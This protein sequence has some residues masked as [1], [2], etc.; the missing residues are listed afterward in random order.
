M[1]AGHGRQRDEIDDVADYLEKYLFVGYKPALELDD[2]RRQEHFNHLPDDVVNK[3][4]AER[5]RKDVLAKDTEKRNEM[6][7]EV[8]RLQATRNSTVNRFLDDNGIEAIPHRQIDRGITQAIGTY[9]ERKRLYNKM[10]APLKEMG[11]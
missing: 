1:G 4:I 5:F 7:T 9:A 8:E 3:I 2:K 11:Y 6:I 10:L